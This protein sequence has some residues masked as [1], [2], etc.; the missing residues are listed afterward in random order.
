MD[1]FNELVQ[2]ISDFDA[3]RNNKISEKTHSEMVKLLDEFCEL[4]ESLSLIEGFVDSMLHKNG[5]CFSK[6]SKKLDHVKI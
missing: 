6:Y 2:F 3:E 5:K 4:G 1:R